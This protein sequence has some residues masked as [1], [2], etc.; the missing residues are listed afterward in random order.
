[1]SRQE[2]HSHRC[3]HFVCEPLLIDSSYDN[4]LQHHILTLYL[5]YESSWIII[6]NSTILFNKWLID[7]RRL[8]IAP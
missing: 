2:D 3:V 5:C 1:M 8:R 7:T 4:K 6:S